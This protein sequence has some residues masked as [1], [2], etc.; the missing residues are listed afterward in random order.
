MRSVPELPS[1]LFRQRLLLA[2]LA[3]SA[4]TRDAVFGVALLLLLLLV[5]ARTAWSRIAALAAAFLL[6]GA[7]TLTASPAPED[8][9]SWASV[10]RRNVLA[11]GRIVSVSG[12]PGERIRVILEK[13]HPIDMPRHLSSETAADVARALNREVPEELSGGRKGYPGKIFESSDAPVPGR[14]SMTLYASDLKSV[15]RPVPGG[16]LRAVLRLYPSVGSVNPGTSDLGAYWADRDVWH[17]ARL[18]RTR[19]GPLFLEMGEGSGL[20]W[21]LE[22][23]R[24][25]WL[26][27][28]AERACRRCRRRCAK[29]LR[30][31]RCLERRKLRPLFAGKGHARGAAV[32]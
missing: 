12:L 18:N 17:N 26:E 6:G 14:V 3:G 16:T 4:A 31:R 27:G 20:L 25:R 8:C 7:V 29:R 9:P 21:H 5:P 1:L 32:R 2:V 19:T 15:G 22:L 23:L 28:P 13:M 10:P 30:Q 11:E 24:L